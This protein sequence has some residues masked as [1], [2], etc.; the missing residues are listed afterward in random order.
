MRGS[1]RDLAAMAGWS[2]ASLSYYERGIRDGMYDI[3]T[4]LQLGMPRA[5]LLPLVFA[6]AA[7]DLTPGTGDE[8]G[9]EVLSSRGAPEHQPIKVQTRHPSGSRCGIRCVYWSP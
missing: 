7:A 9:T 2:Q 5:A 1:K 8:V 6:D 3:R 4:A